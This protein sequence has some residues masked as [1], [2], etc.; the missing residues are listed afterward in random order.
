MPKQLNLKLVIKGF[1][2]FIFHRVKVLMRLPKLQR[3]IRLTQYLVLKTKF[4]RIYA[5]S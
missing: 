2:N 3:E 4:K 1:P 5:K